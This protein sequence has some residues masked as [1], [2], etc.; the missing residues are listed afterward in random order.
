MTLCAIAMSDTTKPANATARAAALTPA[1]RNVS[2]VIQKTATAVASTRSA[3]TLSEGRIESAARPGGPPSESS[4]HRRSEAGESAPTID[5]GSGTICSAAQTRHA[6]SAASSTRASPR[7]STG[8][9]MAAATC[10]ERAR[11]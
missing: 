5:A 3:C 6:T 7:A 9:T 4:P 2:R 10:G 11:S 1:T 8:R